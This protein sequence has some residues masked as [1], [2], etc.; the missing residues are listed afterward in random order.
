ML[1][2][3]T[4]FDGYDYGTNAGGGCYFMFHFD[5]EESVRVAMAALVDHGVKHCIVDKLSIK[6]NDA[7]FYRNSRDG[8]HHEF[9]DLFCAWLDARWMSLVG[10]NGHTEMELADAIEFVRGQMA[11]EMEVRMVFRRAEIDRWDRKRLQ[12]AIDHVRSYRPGRKP[13]GEIVFD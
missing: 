6:V 12:W 13:W 4:R 3:I 11:N 10:R 2:W 1:H 9:V 5:S 7:M 8:S